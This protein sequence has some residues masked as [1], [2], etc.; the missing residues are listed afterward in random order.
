MLAHIS[1]FIFIKILRWNPKESKGKRVFLI[2]QTRYLRPENRARIW[3]REEHLRNSCIISR[4]KPKHYIITLR[5]LSPSSRI[6]QKHKTNKRTRLGG[7]HTQRLQHW[8]VWG[9]TETAA[10][11]RTQ[12]L[13]QGHVHRDCSRDTY[14][15]TAAGTR[16]GDTHTHRDC[17]RDSWHLEN[18]KV[19]KSLPFSVQISKTLA[20]VSWFLE[21]FAKHCLEE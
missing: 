13:Q 6:T 14:T 21:L 2:T 17:S 3:A 9:D 15:E 1:L 19:T 5:S 12:R 7:T 10:G 4:T 18:I 20:K 11:T 8:H 16:L